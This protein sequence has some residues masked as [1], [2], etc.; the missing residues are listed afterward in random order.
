MTF[1]PKESGLA[2]PWTRFVVGGEEEKVPRKGGRGRRVRK[3]K[4]EEV[5]VAGETALQELYAQQADLMAKGMRRAIE[6]GHE[7]PRVLAATGIMDVD[8]EERVQV[9]RD[10]SSDERERD[11]MDGVAMNEWLRDIRG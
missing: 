4:A 5:E 11:E 9:V 10:G 8:A 1:P 7:D 2:I 6:K 3:K